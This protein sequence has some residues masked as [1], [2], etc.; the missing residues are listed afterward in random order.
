MTTREKRN[1]TFENQDDRLRVSDQPVTIGDL[2][3]SARVINR[4]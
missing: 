3:A 1:V 2:V 4:N